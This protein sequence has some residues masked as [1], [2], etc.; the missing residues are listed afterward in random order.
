MTSRFKP[1][2]LMESIGP[3]ARWWIMAPY[4]RFGPIVKEFGAPIDGSL[5]LRVMRFARELADY[6][7]S[8]TPR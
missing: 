4:A 2:I 3:D 8:S 7:D 6:W 5:Q 1:Q